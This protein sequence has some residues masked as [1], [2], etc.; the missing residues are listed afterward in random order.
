MSPV[1]SWGPRNA[2]EERVMLTSG[3]RPDEVAGRSLV[4]KHC[5]GHAPAQFL[6]SSD[7]VPRN[8][9]RIRDF[10][11]E[12][13]STFLYLREFPILRPPISNV[14]VASSNLNPTG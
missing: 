4:H 12:L 10:A 2:V 6:R 11:I 9:H 1:H 14:P 7:L 3:Y 13:A 5:I 8:H